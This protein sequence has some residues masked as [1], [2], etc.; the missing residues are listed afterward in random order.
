MNMRDIMP[1][2][3]IEKHPYEDSVE[4]RNCG[5]MDVVL[6]LG[7]QNAQRREVRAS[8]G[9]TGGRLIL[10]GNESVLR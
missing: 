9:A 3:I 8:A 1:V 4:H 7:L 6:L 10:D 2:S 5:H